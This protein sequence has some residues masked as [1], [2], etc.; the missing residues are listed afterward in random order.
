MRKLYTSTI[1]IFL[2]F[3]FISCTQFTADI[4]DYL[5]YWSTEV[6]STNFTIDTPYTRVGEMPY[7]SSAEDVTVT[8][9]LRN[10]KKLTLKMPTSSDNVIRFPGL[11]TQPQYGTAKDYTLTQTTSNK[12]TLTYKKD[13][14]QAHEWGSGDIGAEI[15]FIADDNRV[16]DK[17]FSM[18]F[19]V[20]TPPPKPDFIVA[21]TTGTPSYYVLCITVPKTDMQETIAGGLLH[22]D[23][24]RID[25][26][27]TPYSF[28]VNETEKKFVKPEADAFITLS[29]VT[30]LSEPDADEV[31]TDGWVLYYKTDAEV[32]DGAAKKDYTITLADEKGLVS[33]ALNA[34]TK[35]N[36]PAPVHISLVKGICTADV[37]NDNTETTP[38]T[39]AVG[40]QNKPATLRLTSAT[41]NATISYTLTETSAGS[42]ASPSTGSG[43]GSGLDIPLPIQTGKTEAEYMLTVRAEADGFETGAE[44][45]LYYKITAQNTDTALSALKLTEGSDVY[46]AAL[47][48]G[49]DSAYICKIPFAE[50]ARTLT[51][52]ATTV[53]SRS[54]ITAV[55]VNGTPPAGFA[56]ANTVTLMNAVTLPSTLPAAQVTVKITVTGEDTS[57]SKE[58][59]LTVTYSAKDAEVASFTATAGSAS[60]IL[61]SWKNPADEDLYQVEITASPA[62]G[63]LTNPVY[64]SAKKGEAGS[65]TVTGLAADTEYTLTVKTIDKALNKSAGISKT[66]RTQTAPVPGAPMEIRLSQSPS[67]PTNGNVTISFT[68]STSVKTAKWAKGVKTV[69]EVLASGTPI[70]GN[71]FEVSENAKYS[72]GVQDNEGRREVEIIEITN[73]DKK[74]PAKVKSLSAVYDSG[75]QKIIVTWTNPTDSDFAG[76]ILSW[77]KGGGDATNV[78]L[79]KDKTGYELPVTPVVGDEYT[80]SVRAK[81]DAGNES[82]PA[83]VSVT[84]SLPPSLTGIELS[85]AHLAY[86]DTDLTIT[87][88]LKGSNFDLIASQSDPTVKAGIFKDNTLVG[89]LQNAAAAGSDYTVTLT[90]P[91]LSSS[92]ATV[93]GAVYTVRVKLCGTY[94]SVTETFVISK[95]ARLTAQPELSVTQIVS[96]EVTSSSK[97]QITIKGINLDIAGGITVQLYD[98]N[99]AAYGSAAPID[100]SHTGRE[101]TTLTADIPVPS[102]EGV[103]TAKV[104]F[105]GVIQTSYYEGSTYDYQ[106]NIS[107]PAIQVYGS[108]K[109]TSFTIPN[110]G[111]SKENSTVMAAVKGAN[112]K[113]PGVTA[114]DF[115]VS[116]ATA[117]ITDSSAITIIDDATLKVSLTI[118]GIADNYTVTVTC[119]SASIVG[120]FSVK[121]YAAYTPGKIVLADKTLKSKDEYAGIDSSN[122]PVAIIAGVNGYGAALGIALHISPSALRW[123][124]SGST[125]CNTKFEGI[126]CTPQGNNASTATFTGDIDGSDNWDYIC[127]I[128]PEGTAN[129]AENYPA[130]HWVNRYN[131]E[132]AGKLGGT[133]FAWY[134]P[135]LAE[136]CEVYRNCEAINASLAKIHGLE[137]GGSYA[138]SSLGTSWFWS[139]SQYSDYNFYA[140][141]VNFYNGFVY[142]Y[143]KDSNC[144]VCCLAGF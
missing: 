73:I 139:S 33:A 5:S 58:Y 4:E 14:L 130:F 66:V 2:T 26:N 116:C 118:P 69:D 87:A 12:L 67:S 79:T 91:R 89:N 84:A 117:S 72:V 41:A 36:R 45:T 6:A 16:F 22:K 3:L 143:L 86:N 112:F 135:S 59:T 104:L 128:D 96:S 109:F 18:N 136:L 17:R 78:P 82:E 25:I 71:S 64:L 28:S 1:G 15:T 131:E 11:S 85:R 19:K 62:A 30:K 134:M 105:G 8:I 43:A 55:T 125:G 94:Q 68:S 120:T 56:P 106:R 126:I 52:T 142:K 65:Y 119:G 76:L 102:D 57:V 83:S 51:L 92:E 49:S 60:V 132:Y 35:P 21:K 38:H 9:K 107:H 39:I 90:A 20:N 24:K 137:N 97:T 95:E 114:S 75:N 110:A 37:N 93:E 144:R 140:W 80:V 77:K 54:T 42:T 53:N 129:A 133:N 10:P 123:A 32:K 40:G 31:P 115:S 108:P 44:R 29:D 124:K 48:A 50:R 100:T 101:L 113:V 63:T 122:P 27:G 13:F 99:G 88:T 70:T 111:I 138:D 98:S 103:F 34:S 46:S 74:P 141:Q 127:S 121:D 81:D 7:V 23:I 61:L 47:I